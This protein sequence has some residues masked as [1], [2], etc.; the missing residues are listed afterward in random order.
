[1]MDSTVTVHATLATQIVGHTTKLQAMNLS[2]HAKQKIWGV[3]YSL[4]KGTSAGFSLLFVP[5][6]DARSFRFLLACP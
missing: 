2:H 5:K 1:M 3:F 6:K 4:T